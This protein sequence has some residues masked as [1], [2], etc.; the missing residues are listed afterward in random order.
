MVSLCMVLV[1]IVVES[2][3][4]SA[5]GRQLAVIDQVSCDFD[6]ALCAGMCAITYASKQD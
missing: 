1:T 5:D 3:D 2:V 6:E 4:D